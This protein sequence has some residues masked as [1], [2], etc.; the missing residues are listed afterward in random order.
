MLTERALMMK[1]GELI[2]KLNIRQQRIAAHGKA[3]RTNSVIPFSFKRLIFLSFDIATSDPTPASNSSNCEEHS[4][5]KEVRQEISG[6]SRNL[7]TIC[8]RR[9]G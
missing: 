2:P 5:K 8:D 7:G 1:M 6:G 9:L 3:V 4:R